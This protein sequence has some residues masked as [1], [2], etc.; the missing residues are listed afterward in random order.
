MTEAAARLS[1]AV[2]RAAP[3][4][5]DALLPRR[6]L[7]CGT[8]VEGAGAVCP[9]CWTG[10]S[11][12]GPPICACCGF[13]FEFDAGEGAL[14][15]ACTAR[16]PAYR[17][18]RAVFAYDE[19]SRGLPLAFKHADRTD[20]APAYGA[21]LAR[22]G[23]E[24]LADSDLVAPVP[25][26]YTRLLR[27]RYN[28]SA[29]LAAAAARAAQRPC[30]PDLLLRTRRTRSQGGLGRDAR[31]RNVQGAFRVRPRFEERVK[32]ARIVL[33]DD[34]LTTGAT[35]EACA[36]CMLRVGA[37]SVDVLTLARVVRPGA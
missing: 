25:L 26:H 28:Q 6:C 19:A 16:P 37:A 1:G 18:A 20:A 36:R 5:L 33:V 34:V 15:G 4:V 32:G 31:R 24:L 10:I 12:L 21:W 23:A 8:V 13:P 27:R 9:A 2:A 30:V 17:C 14:C 22:A 3:G 35:V 11:F 7:A 29:L